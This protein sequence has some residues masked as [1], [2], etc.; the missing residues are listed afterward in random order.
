VRHLKFIFINALKEF[1]LKV[2]DEARHSELA[3]YLNKDLAYADALTTQEW[4]K[5]E[6]VSVFAAWSQEIRALRV[7]SIGNEF[8]RFLPLF[9]VVVES[10]DVKRNAVTFTQV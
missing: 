3:N 10:E 1:H 2:G 4:E 5:T 8:F 7:K 6:R 9:G